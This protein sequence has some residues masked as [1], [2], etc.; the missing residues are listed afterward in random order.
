MDLNEFANEVLDRFSQEITDLVFL[1]VQ[2]N[3]GLMQEYL[4]AVSDKGKGTV[5]RSLGKAIKTRFSLE[6]L[7]MRE[8][9]PKSTLI[10]SHQE[11]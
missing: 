8:S 2:D 9:A 6:N 4:A 11:F 5:N 3:H 10:K 7:P 1:M